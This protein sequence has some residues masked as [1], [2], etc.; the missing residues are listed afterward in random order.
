MRTKNVGRICLLGI[1]VALG[2]LLAVRGCFRAPAPTPPPFAKTHVNGIMPAQT[3]RSPLPVPQRQTPTTP[4]PGPME[5]TPVSPLPGP[6]EQTPVSALPQPSPAVPPEGEPETEEPTP[7]FSLDAIDR[8][9]EGMDYNQVLAILGSA[10]VA[11]STLGTDSMVYKWTKDGTSLL[12]KFE[13]DK[14]VRKTV[15][16][17][18]KGGSGKEG[19]IKQDNYNQVREGMSLEEVMA[20]FDVNMK[21]VSRPDDTVTIYK[22]SD[23]YGSSFTAKFENGRLVRK[24]GLY[25]APMKQEVSTEGEDTAGSPQAP[26]EAR[27]EA[28]TQPAP[29]A[30]ESP[31]D[32]EPVAEN[33]EES[34]PEEE[35]APATQPRKQERVRVA[36]QERR[37]RESDEKPASPVEG[38]SYKPKA[39]LPQ[40]T[41]S[42]RKGTYSI[43]IRNE[44]ESAV[45]LG[46]RSGKRGWNATL[47]AGGKVTA[48]VDP[49][50]YQL[51]YIYENAPYA[52]Q[53]GRTVT[54]DGAF[55][56]DAAITLIESS[57]AESE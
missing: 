28:S 23:E 26:E 45:K 4:L 56:G 35:P 42:L 5:Q 40:Y 55:L 13:Q 8:V 10:G 7:E 51:Y 1:M 48:K 44:G 36:G 27:A 46:L 16:G 17:L 43:R 15:Q 47:P 38:R 32:R 9:Q 57:S 21:A 14:L 37:A 52:L 12:A 20:L 3:P 39:K 31:V 33:T 25:I 49:G 6:V 50:D 11:V 22:W 34:W 30:K 2:V 53:Q 18:K 29:P 54:I 19:L 24:T 41:Y